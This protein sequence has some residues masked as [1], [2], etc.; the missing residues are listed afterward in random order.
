MTS[1]P[2]LVVLHFASLSG[3]LHQLIYSAMALVT[4]LHGLAID[5]PF[6]ARPTIYSTLTTCSRLAFRSHNTHP[7]TIYTMLLSLSPRRSND[8]TVHQYFY[9]PH[10]VSVT[11]VVLDRSPVSFVLFTPPAPFVV[12]TIPYS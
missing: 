2:I 4:T 6:A 5:P 9:P 7:I 1:C 3:S 12:Y 11:S 10:P 8:L